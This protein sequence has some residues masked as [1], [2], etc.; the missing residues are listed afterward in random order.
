MS[1]VL[2]EEVG[3]DES[4]T[5]P[6]EER[7]V[8]FLPSLRYDDGGRWRDRAYCLGKKELLPLFFTEGIGRGGRRKAIVEQAQAVCALC[9][10]R[11]ECFQFAKGN[12]FSDG[13][14]GGVDFYRFQRNKP[15][16]PDDVD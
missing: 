8:L 14:W 9:S 4:P 13:I 7:D 2:D 6:A 11:R 1:E 16:I 10:V 15:T 5:T 12:N 3:G